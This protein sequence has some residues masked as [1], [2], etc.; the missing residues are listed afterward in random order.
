MR[1]IPVTVHG[2]RIVKVKC[3]HHWII[4]SPKGPTSR[5]ICRFC[6]AKSEFNN[7]V[8]YPSS[9]VAKYIPPELDMS[10]TRLI[11]VPD[12]FLKNEMQLDM[13]ATPLA[14]E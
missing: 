7:Y 13:R 11:K 5:G 10:S 6:G 8:P 9:Q 1:R 14:R 4:E 2:K 12:R 3:A